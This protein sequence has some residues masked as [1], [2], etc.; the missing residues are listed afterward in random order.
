MV[1]DR[2][3]VDSERLQLWAHDLEAVERA[4]QEAKRALD[5]FALSKDAGAE[6]KVNMSLT[7]NNGARVNGSSVDE[8]VRALRSAI[9]QTDADAGRVSAA[10]RKT[11]QLF[12]E[13]EQKNLRLIDAQSEGFGDAMFDAFQGGFVS[14]DY[15]IGA[16][17]D[18]SWF[19]RIYQKMKDLY[20]RWANQQEYTNILKNLKDGENP[21]DNARLREIMTQ[22]LVYSGFSEADARAMV[23]RLRNMP[24]K[25][26]DYR[27]IFVY[28][29][30]DYQ[31]TNGKYEYRRSDGTLASYTGVYVPSQDK[32]YVD[33]ASRPTQEAFLLTYF[34]ESGHAADGNANTFTRN[35]G[36][37]KAL[38]ADTK[39]FIQKPLDLYGGDLT[40]AQKQHV[41]DAFMSGACEEATVE[42]GKPVGHPPAYLSKEEK[43]LYNKVVQY[44]YYELKKTPYQSDTI[45]WD[46]MTGM[47]NNAMTSGGGHLKS[48]SGQ[49]YWYGTNG[50]HTNAACSEAWAEH[51]SSIINGDSAAIEANRSQMP[52]ATKY[53]D[54]LAS[55][56]A[57]H[58]RKKVRG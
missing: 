35:D 44:N 25:Y 49:N 53:M 28:S 41:M 4:I 16:F 55:E 7:L 17:K 12:E 54:Q 31:K 24:E 18:A 57:K 52:N 51:Y 56:A 27:D 43:E 45:A 6:L 33:R 14:A 34:H 10:V 37:Y 20:L 19:D 40:D 3:R 38:E 26:A 36:L 48:Y 8:C 15:I 9:Q 23:D 46:V 30:Y 32:I 2:V 1:A 21:M 13:A 42:N 29:F 47:T 11:A 58:Y 5:A 22:E 50:Q 39:A